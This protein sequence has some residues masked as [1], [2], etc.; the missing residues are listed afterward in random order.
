MSHFNFNHFL[1]RNFLLFKSS[2]TDIIY[3]SSYNH[4]KDIHTIVNKI[5]VCIS[6][7]EM[8][9]IHLRPIS[10]CNFFFTLSLSVCFLIHTLR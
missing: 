6:L 7:Y 4:I 3:K 2:K 9:Y 5:F 8:M 1:F 10:T